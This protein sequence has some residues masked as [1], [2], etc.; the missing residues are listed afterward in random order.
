MDG[1]IQLF[2]FCCDHFV[3]YGRW[4]SEFADFPSTDAIVLCGMA[5]V[6][7]EGC[8]PP[9]T[10]VPHSECRVG[11]EAAGPRGSVELGFLRLPSASCLA[12]REDGGGGC[13]MVA[14]RRGWLVVC[15]WRM[16]FSSTVFFIPILGMGLHLDQP[17]R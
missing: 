3:W 1:E 17:W 12:C 8:W 2:L 16:F 5:A 13:T 9:C 11:L 6:L 10:C 15:R 4:L 7:S 14:L